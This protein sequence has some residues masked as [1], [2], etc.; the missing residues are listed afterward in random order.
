[1]SCGGR[2][3]AESLSA[4]GDDAATRAGDDASTQG[5]DDA[6][7]AADAPPL[8]DAGETGD[9]FGDGGCTGPTISA[10]ECQPGNP[11]CCKVGVWW[12][13]GS[14]NYKLGGSCMGAADASGSAWEY[15]C[16]ENGYQTSNATVVSPQPCPCADPNALFEFAEAHCGS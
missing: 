12:T 10:G 7:V 11:S 16:T 2:I 6:S 1:M 13:C 15:G 8:F 5:I 14:T 3:A 4:P 9:V